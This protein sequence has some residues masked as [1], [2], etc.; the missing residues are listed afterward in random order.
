MNRLAEFLTCFYGSK[1]RKGLNKLALCHP[2]HV[3]GL[4]R[5]GDI[6]CLDRRLALLRVCLLH[7]VVEDCD[8]YTL[9]DLACRF[10]LT[11]EEQEA[12]RLLDRHRHDDCAYWEQI[13]RHPLA[14]RAKVADRIA[15]LTDLIAWIESDGRL[16]CGARRQAEKYLREN[17]QVAP[18]FERHVP[19][20]PAPGDDDEIRGLQCMRD[21]MDHLTETLKNTMEQYEN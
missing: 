11:E 21:S 9:A 18:L 19:A 5:L 4:A 1:T 16:V 2:T 10:D 14:L 12:L 15:N 13:F 8:R 7:D 20:E 3:A 6:H 17:E